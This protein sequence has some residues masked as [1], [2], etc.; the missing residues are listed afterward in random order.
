MFSAKAS[1][2]LENPIQGQETFLESI[3]VASGSMQRFLVV[4]STYR[5]AAGP[6]SN[7]EDSIIEL[8][9]CILAFQARAL[10]YL[11]HHRALGILSD[12]FKPSQWEDEVKKIRE[13]EQDCKQIPG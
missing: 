3:D 12:T 5:V 13:K 10:R 6:A 2:F 1:K 4:E 7:L 8:Y 9:F 11:V